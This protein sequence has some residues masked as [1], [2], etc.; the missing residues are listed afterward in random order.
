[1]KHT[2]LISIGLL[3]AATAGRAQTLNVVTGNVTT[4]FS[5]DQAG[6]MAYSDNGA[7]LTI[8]GKTYNTS[9][10]T[11]MYVD[12]SSVTDY[13]VKVAYNGTTASVTIAGN[14]AAQM[15][16]VVKNA[17][18]ALYQADDVA[19]EI[20]YTLSGTSTDG[21]FYMDGE[22]KCTIALNGL[23]LHNPD[24]AA[25][26]IRDGKRIGVL[27]TD[28]T[29]NTLTDGK[30]GSQKACFAVKGHAEF[31]GGGTLNITGN[32]AHAF[33]GKEY[34][35]LKKKTGTIN[36]L[37]AVNDGF[38]VNQYFLQ[39]G[40]T[41]S[42]KGVG[43]DGIAV[44]YKTDDNDQII[45]LTEDADNTGSMTINGG[46]L[47]VAVTAADSKGLKTEG[48]MTFNDGTITVTNTG[49]STSSGGNRP[50]GGG[51]WGGWGGWGGSSSSSTSSAS[52]AIKAEGAL[53]I[54]GGTISATASSHEA[55]ESKSTIDISGGYVYA[56]GSDDAIN[57]ASHFTISGGYVMGYSTGND[58][59]D[60]N[61]N[62]YIKGGTV[63]AIGSSSPEMALD[64]NTEGGY[65][66]YVQG[67]TLIAI[68]GLE[69]G[70]S[71][72]QTCYKSSSWSKNAWYS[73]T[74]G[75]DVIAFKT[76]SSGGSGL[77]VS[78]SSQPT[79]K[80]G[81]TTSGGTTMP[82]GMMVIGPTVS[83]GS[84][85]SLSSYSGGSGMGGGGRW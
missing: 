55:I 54:N 13:A 57:A 19:D 6:K 34:V 45:P 49:T 25:I 12:E 22:Y 41:V 8:N 67:G 77:V 17:H 65:K 26:N 5:A 76:P 85:V 32:T 56:Q 43:D 28:G 37:G 24:S 39:N 1:M 72:T 46:T 68:G 61:G 29:T 38:N 10:I 9:D 51:S 58:G 18:V 42:I 78:A 31:T 11:Q 75:S 60:A 69:N 66:L 23:T 63:Y 71:L 21:S 52:K 64:A 4:Q 74:N 16:A 59:L 53:T 15:T 44:S 14:I 35:Q 47:T 36:V 83:S 82:G 79:V 40:G 50:G 73:L 33:W 3:M 84:S 48:A 30:N 62:M 2:I 7:S 81:V 20:T 70:A 27:L 80:S